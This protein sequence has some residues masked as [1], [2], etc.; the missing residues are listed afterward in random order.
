MYLLVSASR[1]KVGRLSLRGRERGRSFEVK[2]E[3]TEGRAK[4]GTN[5]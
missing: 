1:Y 5:Q 3:M 2:F 4:G